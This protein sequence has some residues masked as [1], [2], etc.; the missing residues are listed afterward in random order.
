M[1]E[2][3]VSIPTPDGEMSGF[4]VVPRSPA[5][6]SAVVVAQEAFGVN[7]HIRDVCR[8]LAGDGH[9]ALAPQ[10]YHRTRRNVVIDYGNFEAARTYLNELTNEGIEI[11]VKASVGFLRREPAVGTSPVSAIGFC[12]GGFVAFLAACRTDVDAS[13]CFYGGGIVH[14]RPGAQMTP[15]LDEADRIQCPL[16]GLFGEEDPSIPPEDVAAIRDRLASL[17]K[18]AEIVY[19]PGA[20]HGFFCDQRSSY[21]P[22]AAKDAWRRT[23]EWLTEMQTRN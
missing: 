20:G 22:D 12:M 21:R 11:D 5:T 16:L 23:L 13:V 18:K 2:R 15:L 14:A 4:F 3:T 8:R 10:L 7:D 19:Y 9:A 1:D 17:G 6:R